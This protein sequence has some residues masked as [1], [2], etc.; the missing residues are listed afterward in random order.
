MQWKEKRQRKDASNERKEQDM[1]QYQLSQKAITD[2][3][4]MVADLT[5]AIDVHCAQKCI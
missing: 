3:K 1:K 2:L 5:I 4:C